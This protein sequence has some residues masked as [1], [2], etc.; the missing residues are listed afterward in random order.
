MSRIQPFLTTPQA[1]ILIP[2]IPDTRVLPLKHKSGH[3]IGK[4]LLSALAGVA[5]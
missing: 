1:T 4:P 3:D 5:P 2:A